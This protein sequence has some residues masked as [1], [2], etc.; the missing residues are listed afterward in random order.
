MINIKGIQGISLI[1]YPGKVATT[2]F[3]AGCNFRCPFCHNPELIEDVRDENTITT[4]R[5][6]SILSKRRNFIDGV[7]ITG[8]EPLINENIIEFIE[9]L[10]GKTGLDIKIDTN[11]YTP[12][13]LRKIIDRGLVQYIAMDIKTSP[14]RYY[15]AA[16]IDMKSERIIKS[17]DIIM[18]SSIPY[19]FRTTVVPGI[20]ESGDIREICSVIS[21]ADK[22]ALQQYRNGKTLDSRYSDIHP[23]KPEKIEKMRDIA[24]QFIENVEIRGI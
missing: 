14:Q 20:V 3:T 11:G 21:G 22:Y 4:D 8:G 9:L 15:E 7:C 24:K 6:F 13:I 17:I 18:A 19:E 12:D 10:K 2:I 23:Y 5:I 16:G 1:D